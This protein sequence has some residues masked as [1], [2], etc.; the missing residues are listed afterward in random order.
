MS[1]LCRGVHRAWVRRY[2]LIT[3]SAPGNW[4]STFSAGGAAARTRF[5]IRASRDK[6][7]G[8]A[9]TAGKICWHEKDA[10]RF[11]ARSIILSFLLYLRF[12][13]APLRIPRVVATIT[14]RY[15]RG[16]EVHACIESEEIY[17]WSVRDANE[18]RS[19]LTQKDSC[20][21]YTL[22]NAVVKP[23]LGRETGILFVSGIMNVS[24]LTSS[25]SLQQPLLN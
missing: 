17:G 23:D 20:L 21:S 10:C 7:R 2:H 12:F 18:T 22:I 8:I 6:E 19:I 11:S 14:S 24:M 16:I 1:D 25:S 3:A 5:F 4:S 15:T 9:D 13:F